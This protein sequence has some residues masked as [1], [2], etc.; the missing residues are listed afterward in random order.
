MCEGSLSRHGPHRPDKS[1]GLKITRLTA[2]GRLPCRSC[3]LLVITSFSDCGLPVK[4]SAQFRKAGVPCTAELVLLFEVDARSPHD[5]VRRS[6]AAICIAHSSGPQAACWT[7]FAVVRTSSPRDITRRE[8]N[9]LTT[10]L[11]LRGCGLLATPPELAAVAPHA[12]Q[13]HRQLSRDC[14]C[15]EKLT[16]RSIA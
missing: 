9:R 7:L 16:P 8:A 6:N 1:E 10:L 2:T 14:D 12:V 13:D 5:G 11:R 4:R 15:R 3:I